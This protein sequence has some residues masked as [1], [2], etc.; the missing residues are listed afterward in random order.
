M[1]VIQNQKG[2]T[3]LVQ[4]GYIFMKKKVNK[5]NITFI[6]IVSIIVSL[7]EVVFV[8]HFWVIYKARDERDV[9]VRLWSTLTWLDDWKKG[10][11]YFILAAGCFTQAHILWLPIIPGLMLVISGVLYCIK[12]VTNQVVA[13]EEV[14][15]NETYG[16]FD[17][18]QDDIEENLP[19]TVDS[20]SL[21]ETTVADQ[22]QIMDV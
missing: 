19:E 4:E 11:F 8:I 5:T 14:N 7:C 13:V 3:K 15:K 12:T 6:R 10:L 22:D 2:E 20:S 18:V 21:E 17:E 9:C 1:E 16:R